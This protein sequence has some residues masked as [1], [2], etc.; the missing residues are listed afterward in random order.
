MTEVK[1][2]VVVGAG[3]AGLAALYKMRAL[4]LS[5]AGIEQ[6]PDVGG[7]WY[8]NNYPGAR[9]DVESVD[10]SY[11]F[12]DALQVEWE[13]TEKYAAQPEILAYLRHVAERFDLRPLIRFNTRVLSASREAEDRRWL[14]E[15]D[16]G[17]VISCEYLVMASGSLSAPKDPDFAG[18]QDFKGE[19]YQTSF[20]PKD[21][22][23]FE[24]KR[25]GLI[26]TGS[27]GVQSGPKIAETAE[28][29]TVFQRT[30]V[31][32]IPARNG[33][34][35]QEK[36]TAVKARYPEYRE[37][38]KTFRIGSPLYSTGR[39]TTDFTPDELR[40]V[41]AARWE[42]GG[43]ALS[44]SFT[45][46]GRVLEAN[47]KVVA[48][49]HER[50]REIV[51]DPETAELLCPKDHPIGA[52]RICIDTDYY[53]TYNRENVT[54]VD[55]RTHPIER[56]TAAGI[57][58]TEKEYP[59]DMIVFAIGFDAVTGAM[60][61]INITNKE[62]LSIADK[63]RDGAGTYLGL[64][65]AGFPNLFIV[66]GPGSPSV[67][68]NMVA[69]IEHD[70]HWIGDTISY[71]RKNHLQRIE[72]TAEAEDEWT[73]HV[74]EIGSGLLLSKANSWYMGSNIA[75]KKRFLVAYP[76]G[77]PPYRQKVEEIV[78]DGY[79]GFVLS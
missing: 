36:F 78:A 2:V 25:V 28:H 58:T 11:S 30:P 40:Q 18:L 49:V 15:T 59:L 54:L 24:G 74:A 67:L 53:A 19:W 48:F 26:G 77:M 39:P 21:P 70:V 7:V 35:D 41:L 33:P 45:D 8:H 66:T 23:K 31:F 75:G 65:T 73:D 76:L 5:V 55:V 64:M 22:V 1:D 52:R 3:F 34:M 62:G 13:W 27:S 42:A 60:T 14:V 43:P 32:T 10:Y 16:A 4:G 20:W 9:C 79:R 29:L 37:E 50:I 56:I 47:N 68:V 69:A 44:G 72:A 71:L 51:K 63:W 6:A 61:R 38:A 46:A 57:K 12:S 17:D